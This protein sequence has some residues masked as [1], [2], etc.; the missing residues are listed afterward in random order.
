VFV[1]N[2]WYVAAWDYELGSSAVIARQII[3]E[4]MVIYRTASGVTIAME[5]RCCHRSAPLSKGRVEGEAIRCMYHGFKF[6]PDGMCIEIPGQSVIPR[7]ARVRKY[8]VVERYNWI[9]VWMGDPSLADEDLIPAG[10]G[11]AEAGWVTR[12]GQLD[13]QAHYELLNDNLTDFTHL[14][15]V[16]ANSFRAP[17]EF[18]LTR[19]H[20]ERL[21]RGLRVWR[22]M[23]TRAKPEGIDETQPMPVEVDTWTQYDYLAP[24]VFTMHTG[25]FPKGTADRFDAD[26]RHR[27]VFG[28]RSFRKYHAI[29]T[30][31]GSAAQADADLAAYVR[32]Q[33]YTVHH[34]V[35]SCR[36]GKDSL[37]VVD[38]QLRL[39]GLE[40]LR[41]VD[42]SV[43]PSI[44]GG[45]TNAAVVMVA[46][47]A[48][49]MIAGRPPLKAS[50]SKEPAD[51][52]A[53][54]PAPPSLAL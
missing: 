8:P 17:A 50:A 35:S 18:A 19:P 32:A 51:T 24:G 31:P 14:T 28:A 48:A 41:V 12:S 10:F 47:K 27:K 4:A 2:C 43:F 33:A 25:V 44:I 46:E 9:G 5:D 39:S 52:P 26:E 54:V 29:E 21:D 45:N 38:P 15:Y 23:D 20:I 6:D 11:L 30:A 1:R 3:G 42:A 53:A 16:H 36:M 7:A 22:W 40:G 13:Y 34:P 37:A 49:D